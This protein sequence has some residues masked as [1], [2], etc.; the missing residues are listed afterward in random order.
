MSKNKDILFI[1]TMLLS[2]RF[3]NSKAEYIKNMRAVDFLMEDICAFELVS[4]MEL[5]EKMKRI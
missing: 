5:V 4:Y 1:E 2:S 3:Y